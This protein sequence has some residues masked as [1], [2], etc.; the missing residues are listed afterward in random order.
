MIVQPVGPSGIYHG[1]TGSSETVRIE[2]SMV[3]PLSMPRVDTSIQLLDPPQGSGI[4]PDD[5]VRIDIGALP[6]QGSR[7]SPNN[8]LQFGLNAPLYVGHSNA[9]DPSDPTSILYPGLLP[10]GAFDPYY[11]P[12]MSQKRPPQPLAPGRG[13]KR[14]RVTANPSG[15]V[16]SPLD[17]PEG[18]S[19]SDYE[20]F[21]IA[22]LAELRSAEAGSRAFDK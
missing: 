18:R 7:I 20:K 3:S 17:R 9:S 13:P 14:R 8:P 22:E 1:L 4:S 2:G 5:P 19:N 11:S 15:S 10:H 21:L 16:P 12:N 6:Y